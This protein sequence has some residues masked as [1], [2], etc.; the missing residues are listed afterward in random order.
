MRGVGNQH[1]EFLDGT[2]RHQ[3][4]AATADQQHG[5]ADRTRGVGDAVLVSSRTVEE[6]QALVPH[7]AHAHLPEATH[8][9]AGD[10]NDAFTGTVL[11][12][13]AALPAA[14]A[15]PE[16]TNPLSATGESATPTSV[17]GARP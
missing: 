15:I 9:L 14:N 8:M 16:A 2:R 17:P 7:A 3:V 6:F 4:A 1:L 5:A 10:D 11:E 12:Y 13:L